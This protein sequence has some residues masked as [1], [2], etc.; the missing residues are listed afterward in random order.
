[1]TRSPF[2]WD[3]PPGVSESEAASSACL[4]QIHPEPQKGN[5]IMKNLHLFTITIRP[6]RAVPGDI[7]INDYNH[8]LAMTDDE[9]MSMITL[10]QKRI[11]KLD[12][13]RESDIAAFQEKSDA[14]AR[15]IDL[16][17]GD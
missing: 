13:R 11:A 8:T 10:V 14:I 15:R 3:Y 6:T 9:A 7:A 4:H 17:Q 2:G 12:A 1:M 16:A 5:R